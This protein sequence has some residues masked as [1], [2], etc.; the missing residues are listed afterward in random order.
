[1]GYLSGDIPE[2]S[3]GNRHNANGQRGKTSHSDC[4]NRGLDGLKNT[5]IMKAP[6][7]RVSHHYIMIGNHF[8]WLPVLLSLV[9][10]SAAPA[11]AFQE[12]GH[13]VALDACGT[14]SFSLARLL[15][16]AAVMSSMCLERRALQCLIIAPRESAHH[17][18]PTSRLLRSCWL[19]PSQ[20]L[21]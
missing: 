16:P 12:S 6:S 2:M 1:M 19:Y 20:R 10:N 8:S 4:C 11:S 13:G 18:H 3:C 7:C 15:T 9:V 5:V 17:S 14:C 21:D